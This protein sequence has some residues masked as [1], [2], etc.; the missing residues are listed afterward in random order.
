MTHTLAGLEARGLIET[1]AHPRDGR[2]KLVHITEAG[3]EMREACIEG[4][5]PRLHA[6]AAGFPRDRA[7][8]LLPELAELRRVLDANRP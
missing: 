8:A 4:L 2:S 5:A 7:A 6:I 3:R 1:R